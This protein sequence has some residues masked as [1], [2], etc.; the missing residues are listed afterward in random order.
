MPKRF[1]HDE[2]ESDK[3]RDEER[4]SNQTARFAGVQ[5]V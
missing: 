5:K 2:P 3:S 4:R 1:G